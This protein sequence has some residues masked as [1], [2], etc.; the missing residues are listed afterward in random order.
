[1]MCAALLLLLLLLLLLAAA[2]R[3]IQ[4]THS[5]SQTESCRGAPRAQGDGRLLCCFGWQLPLWLRPALRGS[6]CD[7]RRD[8]WPAWHSIDR[9][10][11][12]GGGARGGVQRACVGM[13]GAAAH[14]SS[15]GAVVRCGHAILHTSNQSP[16]ADARATARHSPSHKWRTIAPLARPN[17]GQQ[18]SQ[19]LVAASS[20]CLH[21]QRGSPA[22]A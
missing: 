12:V 20:R 2:V 3:G 5:C 8:S 4:L 10:G 19:A 9:G 17:W 15:S 21:T 14:V 1:M 16:R 7:A 13:S 18:V 11:G 6:S 22:T